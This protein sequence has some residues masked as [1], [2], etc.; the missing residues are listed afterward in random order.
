MESQF[1]I[2]LYLPS[3]GVTAYGGYDPT[4]PGLGQHP[5]GGTYGGG[6]VL[7]WFSDIRAPNQT[8]GPTVPPSLGAS[9]AGAPVVRGYGQMTWRYSRLR[10]DEWA[11]LQNLLRIV[12]RSSGT[13]TAGQV[14]IRFPSPITA[15]PLDVS[16][17][18]TPV[19]Q[20]TRQV[21]GHQQ[22]SLVFTQLGV[23]DTPGSIPGV[24]VPLANMPS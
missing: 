13:S 11:Y 10:S 15:A 16:A 7:T 19:G 12:R 5:L 1:G 17:R 14:R 18:L 8:E 23:D 22:I 6:S 9:P 21:W 2:G 24:W 20:W 4:L 3:G